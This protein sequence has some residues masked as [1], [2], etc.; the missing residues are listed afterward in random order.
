MLDTAAG[1]STDDGIATVNPDDGVHE[2]AD[3]STLPDAQIRAALH[4][5]QIDPDELKQG[6]DR[7]F[8]N[9]EQRSKFPPTAVPRYSLRLAR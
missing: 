3:W 8:L 5:L 2:A 1:W 7:R 9:V 6:V 4:P